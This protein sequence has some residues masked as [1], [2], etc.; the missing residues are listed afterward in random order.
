MNDIEYTVYAKTDDRNVIIAINSSAFLTDTTNW[1]EIDE[2]E[3]D[4]YHH[5]QNNYLTAGLTDENGIFNY[6]LTDGKPLLRTA[7]EKAPELEHIAAVQ[8]IAELKAKL[9]ATD[10]ISAKIAEGAATREEYAEELA[11]RAAWR[12]RINELESIER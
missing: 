9:A 4:K 2:G 7:E 8:E 6:K 10:Y 5:A 11:E 12:A 3:G 1:M